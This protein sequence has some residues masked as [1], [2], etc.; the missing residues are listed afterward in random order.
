MNCDMELHQH[1]AMPITV[2]CLINEPNQYLANEIR[3]LAEQADNDKAKQAFIYISEAIAGKR[4]EYFKF[5]AMC[6]PSNNTTCVFGRM[7]RT[8]PEVIVRLIDLFAKH[9]AE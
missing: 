4:S 5:I 2:N 7:C 1:S 6:D 8:K 9:N 3:S